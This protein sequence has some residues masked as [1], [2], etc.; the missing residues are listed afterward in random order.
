MN[1][2]FVRFLTSDGLELQGLYVPAER[3]GAPA[4]AHVHGL[5]GNFYENRFIDALAAS[6]RYR[7]LGFLTFNNRGHDYLADLLVDGG[8]GQPACY[9]QG[10]GMHET[11]GECVEDIRAAL[12]WLSGR[13]HRRLVLEGHSHGALKALHYLHVT[14]DPRV[15]A[16]ALLSP[17]DDLAV[18]RERLGDRF[19]AGRELAAELVAN[20]RGGELMP[21]A[22]YP[23]PT[24]AATFHD[25][26]RP[27]SIA[28]S[29]NLS[30]TDREEF[31][32][33]VS[34]RVPA[35]LAVGTEAEAFTLPAAVFVDRAADALANAPS[36]HCAVIEG[37]PHNYL[38]HEDKLAAAVG[39]W[40]ESICPGLA[41]PVADGAFTAP[42]RPVPSDGDGGAG[43][44]TGEVFE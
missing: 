28:L 16:L 39:R 7:G 37:A 14:G 38:G 4:L 11:L 19:E 24:S 17:S 10:G 43:Q 21:D 23:H 25:C 33:L 2:E 5:D 34:V 3:A 22:C 9:R 30:R 6:C 44:A 18:A 13:G 26:L 35:F 31:P 29:F 32:E 15:A 41:A 20:G 36:F 1:C 27:G 12:A 42:P 8:E 40:L